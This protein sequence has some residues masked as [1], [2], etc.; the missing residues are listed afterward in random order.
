MYYTKLEEVIFHKEL[1]SLTLWNDKTKFKI[2]DMKEVV[3]ISVT[4][5]EI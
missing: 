3:M 4:Y 5:Q 1:K 2:P